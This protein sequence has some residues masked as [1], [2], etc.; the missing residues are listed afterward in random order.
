MSD[1]T[2]DFAQY[3]TDTTLNGPYQRRRQ[4]SHWRTDSDPRQS[5]HGPEIDSLGTNN[6]DTDTIRD[7]RRVLLLDSAD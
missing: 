7:R 2:V 1:I 5:D 6:V 4:T 3:T